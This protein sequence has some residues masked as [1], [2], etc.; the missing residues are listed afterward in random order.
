MIFFTGQIHFFFSLVG[1]LGLFPILLF[2]FL[3]ISPDMLPFVWMPSCLLV[4][5]G[6]TFLIC[7]HMVTCPKCGT[8]LWNCGTRSG[9][10]E[11]RLKDDN[12]ACPGCHAKFL[13]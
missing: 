2:I 6:L 12:D 13:L 10:R 4:V 5:W 3:E 11:R 8:S 7:H 1:W 9:P